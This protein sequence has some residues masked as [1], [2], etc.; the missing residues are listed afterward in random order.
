MAREAAL[1]RLTLTLFGGFHA[2]M[3]SGAVVALPTRKAQALL[4]YLALPDR[5]SVV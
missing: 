1:A 3:T 4:A 5:K 2:Q